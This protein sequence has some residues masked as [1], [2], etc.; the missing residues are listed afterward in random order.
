MAW[1]FE[2]GERLG[3]AFR[4]VAA[5]E[6]A[7]VRAGLTDPGKN[8]ARAIHEARQGFKRLRALARLARPSLGRD[9]GKQNRLWRDAGRQLS[10]S[11]DHTVL[12]ETFD[13]LVDQCGE[14]LRKS[15]VKRLRAQLRAKGADNDPSNAQAVVHGVLQALETADAE[16]AQLPWPRDAKA[17]AKGLKRGQS[18]LQENWREA[19]KSDQSE[20]LHEWRKRVKDQSSQL[21]LF[22]SVAPQAL[23]L[24]H[25]K[26]KRVAELLGEEHDYWLLGNALSKATS[27][28]K[29][30]ACGILLSAAAERRKVLRDEALALGAAFASQSPK[31]FS[32]ELVAAWEN[33]SAAEKTKRTKRRSREA[34]TSRAS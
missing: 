20:A 23:R 28:K 7:K 13:K 27:A 17:L 3:D 31:A 25:A 19:R 6:I 30:P 18:Q 15:D 11:R 10:G 12:L 29:N 21:R 34:S 5:E 8:R 26:E 4:R 24:R 32:Q 16:V 2:P 1:R 33:G 9:F 14:D 22:R